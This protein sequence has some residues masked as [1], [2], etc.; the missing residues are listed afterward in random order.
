MNDYYVPINLGVIPLFLGILYGGRRSGLFL[1]V[2]ITS[3][4]LI[5]GWSTIG[6][7]LNMLVLGYSL[8]P[9]ITSN[10]RKGS[11]T[12][13]ILAVERAYSGHADYCS[14]RD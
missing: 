2:Y 13:K 12:E 11:M 8:L 5:N 1:A 9:W 4:G 6:L 14:L 10:F 7:I 3:Q